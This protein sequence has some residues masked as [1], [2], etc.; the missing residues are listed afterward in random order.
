MLGLGER[1]ISH[2]PLVG[3]SCL[4]QGPSPSPWGSSS[5]H[6][7]LLC[8]PFRRVVRQELQPQQ[9]TLIGSVSPSCSRLRGSQPENMCLS[10]S[11]AAQRA[12]WQQLAAPELTLKQDV[13]SISGSLGIMP[14]KNCPQCHVLYFFC[15][16]SWSTFQESLIDKLLINNLLITA[17][18]AAKPESL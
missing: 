15:W 14:E 7:H 3:R 13:C 11:R 16:T 8:S 2:C 17:Q 6:C 10:A 1:T 4:H 9:P 5:S 18:T 12:P